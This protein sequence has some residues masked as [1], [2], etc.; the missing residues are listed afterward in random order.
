MTW[1]SPDCPKNWPL[2]DAF[3]E[4]QPVPLRQLASRLEPFGFQRGDGTTGPL[5]VRIRGL[6]SKERTEPGARRTLNDDDATARRQRAASLL[7]T[8]HA[9][10]GSHVRNHT[11]LV[12]HHD[13]IERA[14]WIRKTGQRGLF[15]FEEH[16]GALGTT[17]RT[18][19]FLVG[20]R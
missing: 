7:K 18:R 6:S 11:L 9:L 5:I 20:S 16:A 13:Q 8:R 3:E 17:A 14:V 2:S 10:F 19:G 12:V 15:N 4:G 1:Q